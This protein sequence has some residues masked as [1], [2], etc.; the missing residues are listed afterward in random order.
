MTDLSHSATWR[1]IHAQPAIWRDWGRSLDV[2][3]LRGWIAGLDI[4]DVWFCGAGS[5]AFVGDIVV[6]ALE[7]A[8]GPMRRAIPTTDLVSRPQTYLSGRKPLIVNFGRSGNS[9]ET[10]ATLDLLDTLCPTAPRLNIT[11]NGGSVLAMRSAAD[12]RVVVLPAVTHDVGFAMTS[13]FTTMALTALALFDHS[14]TDS[15]I[16]AVLDTLSGGATAILAA[17][18]VPVL[19][20]R[21][22]FMGTGPGAFV[23]REAALKVMELS[24]GRIPALWE[25]TLGFRHGP[26]SFVIGATDLYL[27]TAADSPANL[28]EADL[29]AELRQQFPQCRVTTVGPGGDVDL[30]PQTWGFLLPVILAQV[31]AVGWSDALGLTV[32]DPFQGQGTLSRVVSGV[33]LHG[34][35]GAA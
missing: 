11:C 19:P 18:S 15:A 25:S 3:G 16:P 22:V 10:I 30:P 20:E 28:Y 6:A 13:S 26:K 4:S 33:R 29:A 2:T 12:Q 7:G 17:V 23:A 35:T 8:P 9:S 5:S 24:A 31:L 27:F 34:A 1:E 21:V 32:D 14:V